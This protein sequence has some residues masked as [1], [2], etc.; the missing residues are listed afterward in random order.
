MLEYMQLF[1]AIL[2]HICNRL[3][4]IVS[5]RILSAAVGLRPVGW[6]LLFHA[7]TMAKQCPR[8]RISKNVKSSKVHASKAEIFEF[9]LLVQ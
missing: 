5:Y 7:C 8:H 6:S 4:R 9:P 2:R 3:F 1:S